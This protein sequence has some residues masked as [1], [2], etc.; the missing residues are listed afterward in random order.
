MTTSPPRV[1]AT[2]R[3]DLYLRGAGDFTFGSKS[4]VRHAYGTGSTVEILAASLRRSG[5]RR[6]TGSVL[7]DPTLFSD[8]GGVEFILV[9]CPDPLFGAGCPYGPSAHFE[10]LSGW[11]REPREESRRKLESFQRRDRLRDVR[12]FWSRP[13]GAQS[14]RRRTGARSTEGERAWKPGSLRDMR[15]ARLGSRGPLEPASRRFGATQTLEDPHFMRPM[16]NG[17]RTPVAFNRGLV[18]AT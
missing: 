13:G 6:V 18:N 17:P 8:N 14:W 11:L 7:A 5:I 12:T 3:G 9:L 15:R 4:F 10:G 2:W 16:P 1:G